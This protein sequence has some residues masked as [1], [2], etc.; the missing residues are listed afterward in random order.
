MTVG[1]ARPDASQLSFHMFERAVHPE[2]FDVYAEARLTA[3]DFAAAIRICEA[4]HLVEFR[5]G[6]HVVTEVTGHARQE[7]PRRGLNLEYR[8]RGNRD[9]SV[10][11]PGGIRFHY[12]GHVEK[13]AAEVFAEIQ[14]E[15]QWDVPRAL[16][17]YEFPSV[18]RLTASALSIIRAEATSGSF[19]VHSFHTFPASLSVLRTQSLY[20][21]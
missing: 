2:L 21:F 19:A 17:S 3:D 16:L 1:F 8:L 11:L 10:E 9:T 18:H 4:G 5:R 7:L 13:L 12:S 6:E 14:Q 15:L 20:E